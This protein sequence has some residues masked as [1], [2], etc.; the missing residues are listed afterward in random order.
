MFLIDRTT[1]KW[2]SLPTERDTKNARKYHLNRSQ[3]KKADLHFLNTRH[4]P[5]NNI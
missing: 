1:Q 5:I 2:I 4:H 3:K